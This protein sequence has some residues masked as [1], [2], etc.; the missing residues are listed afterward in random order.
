MTSL[1]KLAVSLTG[2]PHLITP[3]AAQEMMNQLATADP[4]VLRSDRSVTAYLRARLSGLANAVRPHAFE[5]E[6]AFADP[7]PP[8]GEAYSPLWM[9]GHDEDLDWGM[10]LKD[11]IACLNVDTPLYSKGAEWCGD[12]FHGYDTLTQAVRDAMTD[13]R[14]RGLFI[15]MDSPGGVVAGGLE[16]LERTLRDANKPVWVHAE[17][18]CSAA[19]WISAQADRI[20]APKAGMTGSIGAVM[21]HVSVKAALDKAGFTVTPITFG[22]RKMAMAEFNQLDEEALNDLQAMV[23]ECGRQF[24]D[25]VTKGRPSLTAEALIATRAKV[26]DA[27]HSEDERSGLALGFVD[28]IMSEEDA[29]GAFR[30]DLTS[31]A[32]APAPA[33]KAATTPSTAKGTD[34]AGKTTMARADAR[35]R[36]RASLEAQ[37]K[38]MDEEDKAEDEE[39][40]QNADDPEDPDAPPADLEDDEEDD[41]DAPSSASSPDE[42]DAAEEDENKAARREAILAHAHKKGMGALGSELAGSKTVTLSQAKRLI[43]AAARGDKLQARRDH[44]VAV[45]GTGRSEKRGKGAGLKA[46][47]QKRN[48]ARQARLTRR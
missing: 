1:S 29:F 33:A 44:G 23:D 45:M 21:V 9:N 5:D 37:L 2:R 3:T 43:D 25:A 40:E 35:A 18:A 31:A 32:S 19:Y 47:A 27:Y 39:L 11:G 10:S 6:D 30:D 26:Y 16:T 12:W 24:I 7:L 36:K 15:S 20:L 42:P 46:A 38:A 41:G 48:E 22:D 8:G 28:E 4:R 13:D 34:M 14:V 17:Q